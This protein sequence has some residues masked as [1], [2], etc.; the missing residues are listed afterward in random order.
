V[1]VHHVGVL[2]AEL[3]GTSV[4]LEAT[5]DRGRLVRVAQILRWIPGVS[6]LIPA[7]GFA[8]AY[9]ARAELT[10]QVD[11]RRQLRAKRAALAAHASQATGGVRT[12]ALLLRLPRLLSGPVLGREW[13]VEV[14]RAPR[15]ELLDDVFATLR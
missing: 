8:S 12:V 5:I 14:G 1:Q 13:F 11:V 10:H 7:S 2:A 15:G 6:R 3:A 4:V 9:V